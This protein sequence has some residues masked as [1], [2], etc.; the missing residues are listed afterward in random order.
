MLKVFDTRISYKSSDYSLFIIRYS[1][2]KF[3]YKFNKIVNQEIK[4]KPNDL[5]VLVS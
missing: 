4:N 3:M 5:L 1:F 2:I